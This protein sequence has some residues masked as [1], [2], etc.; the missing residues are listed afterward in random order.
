MKLNL[1][2]GNNG[3]LRAMI[4]EFDSKYQDW[5]YHEPVSKIGFWFK[6]AADPSF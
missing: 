4:N 6:I 3:I 5:K 2:C 1:D